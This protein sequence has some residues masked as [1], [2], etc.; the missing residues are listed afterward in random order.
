MP[1]PLDGIRVIECAIFHAGPG[2]SA[3]MGDL[4]AEV[5]KIEQPGVGDPIRGMEKIGTIP[6][7]LPGGRNIFCEGA[8]RNKKSVTVNLRTKKGQDIIHRLVKDA[9][10]FLTNFR[11]P[12][13][14]SMKITYD[15]IRRINK[16]I[17]YA[18][19]SAYGPKGPD[20]DRGG[21]DYQGQARSGIMYSMGEEGMP[22]LVCQF[23][24][25][26]QA[27]AS[28]VSQQII[29]ALLARERFGIAQEIKISI[30]GSAMNLIYFNLLTSLMGGFKVPRHKRSQEHPMRNHYK[31]K[32][33]KWLMMTLNPPDKYWESLCRALE[34]PELINDPRF[35]T[36]EQKLEN[37]EQLVAIFDKIIAARTREK[38]LDIFAGYDFF[39][40]AVN[41]MEDLTEDPQVLENNYLVDFDH[42]AMGKIKIP[43]YPAHFSEC[44]AGI[45]SAVPEL[46]EHTEQVLL[47]LGGYTSEEI[48]TMK[49]EG[50]V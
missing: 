16:N 20:S 13:L 27:T 9:D 24:I 21:F 10:V 23:G 33:G 47:E 48:S 14:E 18:S 40:C 12:A 49:D 17:I 22:P 42:P 39:C 8:N 1:R 4:G 45:I 2:A 6:F 31:C 5:I 15:I 25:I 50:V 32:D 19:V 3:I 26:D 43:G 44:E 35:N 34:H 30:L 29:T 38:W 28:N 37:A 7:G 36:D 11:R 41:T 46:G